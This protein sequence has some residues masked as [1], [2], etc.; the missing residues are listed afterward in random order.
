LDN[1][2]ASSW[3]AL[4]NPWPGVTVSAS[5]RPGD[6]T[7]GLIF[8]GTPAAVSAAVFN[9][10]IPAGVL[11]GDAGLT[12]DRNDGARFNITSAPVPLAVVSNATIAGVVGTPLAALPLT[13]TITLYD[14]TVQNALSNHDA[15]SWFANLP[16]GVMVSANAAAGGSAISLTFS[17]TPLDAS[18]AVFDITIP[19]NILA[20]G[21]FLPVQPNMY[22]RFNITLP[23][24]P[25]LAVVNNVIIGGT[26]G[27]ALSPGQTARIT[28]YRAAALALSNVDA[29]PWFIGLPPGVAASASAAGSDTIV[30]TFSGTP[31]AVSTAV[32][33]IT[34][35]ASALVGNSA[36]AVQHNPYARFN[37]IPAAEPPDEDCFGGGCNAGVGIF[38]ALLMVA[39][40]WVKGLRSWMREM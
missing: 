34:I 39:A 13:A 3:F 32:F 25:P 38:G 1:V 5:A 30:L 6:N 36:L 28:L 23:S 29:S 12:V 4:T 17:G 37:I 21:A 15:A 24:D 19:A 16:R 9:I 27:T 33:N 35:P 31:S 26:V 7:I 11:E 40:L 22:A 8:N 20:G 10:A 18:T 2:N 14:I